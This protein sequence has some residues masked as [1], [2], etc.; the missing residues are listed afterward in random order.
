MNIMICRRRGRCVGVI[1]SDCVAPV[2]SAP[3]AGVRHIVSN[4]PG[5]IGTPIG[6]DHIDVESYNRTDVKTLWIPQRLSRQMRPSLSRSSSPSTTPTQL[7]TLRPSAKPSY[8]P[9]GA[10]NE[11][12][13]AF[14]EKSTIHWRLCNSRGGTPSVPTA[15]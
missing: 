11:V 5:H 12:T 7:P 4:C 14:V 8:M 6:L 13:L 2:S 3:R 9:S 15:P 1:V 10:P